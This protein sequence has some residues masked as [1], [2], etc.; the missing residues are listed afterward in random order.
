MAQKCEMKLLGT[1]GSP[2]VTRV[3]FSLKLKSIPYEYIEEDLYN[4]SELLLT[5]NPVFRR[6]PVLIP[7]NEPPVIESLSI[8]EY[9]DELQPDVHRLLP[10]NPSERAQYRVLAYTFDTLYSPWIKEFMRTRDEKRREELKTLLIGASVM[11]EEALVKFSKGKP[12]FGGDDIGYLD[13]VVGTFLGWFK[14][15]GVVFN[16]NVIDEDRTPRMVEWG[17]RMWS[18]EVFQSVIPSHEIHRKFLD[19]LIDILPPLPQQPA[20]SA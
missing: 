3:Q 18:N 10:S 5:S 19:M 20:V 11:L 13:I 7:A 17:K 12:F 1:A 15:C 2:F 6:I 4:R 14:F 16:F 9:L 8:M